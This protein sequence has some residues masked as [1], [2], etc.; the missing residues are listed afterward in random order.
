MTAALKPPTHSNITHYCTGQYWIWALSMWAL[1][2]EMNYCHSISTIKHYLAPATIYRYKPIL[3]TWYNC[4]QETENH[5]YNIYII[6]KMH[7]YT[8][9]SLCSST[10][11]LFKL[12]IAVC[13]RWKGFFCFFFFFLFFFLPYEM[14]NYEERGLWHLLWQQHHFH[15]NLRR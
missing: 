13:L 3:G 8:T 10:F 4:Q 15:E 6:E 9:L 1:W 14:K 7:K 2:L 5:T 12:P 11:M